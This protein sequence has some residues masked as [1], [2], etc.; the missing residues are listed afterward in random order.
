VAFLLKQFISIRNFGVHIFPG[1]FLSENFAPFVFD[2]MFGFVLPQSTAR[3]FSSNTVHYIIYF[4]K[5]MGKSP[6]LVLQE[7]T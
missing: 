4:F 1:P 2:V 7:D 3:G 5:I 6:S